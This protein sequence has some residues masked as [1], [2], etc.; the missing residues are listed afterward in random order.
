[1]LP[2]AGGGTSLSPSLRWL[3]ALQVTPGLP[4]RCRQGWETFPGLRLRSGG[5]MGRETLQRS[6]VSRRLKNRR[7]KWKSSWLDLPGS[8]STADSDLP[9]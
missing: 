5:R 4:S 3:R 9:A 1:M 8:V 7:E 6:R 2:A